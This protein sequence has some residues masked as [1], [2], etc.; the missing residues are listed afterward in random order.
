MTGQVSPEPSILQDLMLSPLPLMTRE[1]V[2]MILPWRIDSKRDSEIASRPCQPTQVTQSSSLRG[3]MA[4]CVAGGFPGGSDGK[5]VCLQCGRPGF[6]LWVRKIPWRRK[7]QPTPVLLP[8]KFHGWRNL[9]DYSPWGRKES[10][11]TEWLP[12]LC[13]FYIYFTLWKWC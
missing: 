6:N 2:S 7:W 12:L 1:E 8:G 11:T 10:D 3:W 4:I 13:V 5:S 9:V